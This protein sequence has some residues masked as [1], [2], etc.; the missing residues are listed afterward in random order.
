MAEQTVTLKTTGMHCGSCAMLIQMNVGDLAG[1]SA[2][3]ADAASGTTEVTFDD[4]VVTVDEIAGEI[5]K[6]GYGVEA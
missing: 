6:A 4:A 5:V 3:K 2:V 1:V